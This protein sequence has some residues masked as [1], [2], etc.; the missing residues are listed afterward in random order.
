MA[1]TTTNQTVY[2]GSCCG[3][4]YL[5]TLFGNPSGGLCNAA[6]DNS[7]PVTLTA[8]ITLSFFNYLTPS[9]Y[10]LPTSGSFDVET[11]N[12]ALP[13]TLYP[14]TAL[15]TCGTISSPSTHFQPA[16]GYYNYLFTVA[17]NGYGH[18]IYPT[19]RLC[20]CT[21]E[22][23]ELLGQGDPTFSMQSYLFLREYDCSIPSITFGGGAIR[24]G[25]LYYGSWKV[26][27]TP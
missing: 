23:F 14:S 19:L 3:V 26:T 1:G 25:G 7:V 15:T 22:Q 18:V 4:Y 11:S 8:T 27:F 10:C 5:P 6:V 2:C 9:D 16:P 24:K 12:S 17:Q 21:G 13:S 20:G